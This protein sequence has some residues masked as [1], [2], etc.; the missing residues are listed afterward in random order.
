[1]KNKNLGF[2]AV[3]ISAIIFGS[4]PLLAKLIY[5]NGGNSIS[6]IFYRFFLSLPILYWLV[7]KNKS[8][9]I[10]VTKLELKNLILVSVFGYSA[11]ALLLFI[12]YNYISSGM[13]TTL[14]F[15]YPIFVVLGSMIFY[16]DKPSLLK[17]ICVLSCTVGVVLFS[18]NTGSTS[19]LGITAAFIS[20]ITYSF[21]ILFIDKSNL[22]DMHPFKLTF[23][24]CL[25]SSIIVFVYSLI[26]KTFTMDMTLLGWL[27]TILLS[28]L[29]SV[30][31]VSLFQYG[32]MTVGSQN[33]AIFSTFEPITSVIIGI[34]V[35]YEAFTL[36]TFIGSIFI[37]A[38]VVITALSEGSKEK[39]NRLIKRA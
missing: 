20:G 25:I 9:D 4:M 37:L 31:A 1:M 32:I 8:I 11:T 30:G 36:R 39:C 15:V 33:T 27:L 17:I 5:S 24:L 29:V 14:H 6:L 28:L 16:K 35:F 21:Y 12:S 2:I 19:L 26:T 13:A 3:I 22:K 23:Y 38:A 10:K 7:K 18:E 34:M